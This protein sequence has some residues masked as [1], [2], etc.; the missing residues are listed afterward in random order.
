M[1]VL[2]LLGPPVVVLITSTKKVD[3]AALLAKSAPVLMVNDKVCPQGL[4]AP[5]VL[6]LIANP[7]AKSNIFPCLTSV[8]IAVVDGPV[9][10]VPPI[11]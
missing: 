1:P 5:E 4:D 10:L 6:H 8:A 3:P 2:P 9:A 7:L 11:T